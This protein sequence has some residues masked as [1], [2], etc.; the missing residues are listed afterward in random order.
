MIRF[1]RYELDSTQGLTRGSQEVRLTP[2]SLALLHVLAGRPGQVVTKEEL[3]RIVW[4]D[5]AVSDAAL[6]SCIQEL[7]RAL[8][9]DARHPRYIETLHR[10]G[11]RF[12][13]QAVPTEHSRSAA[14]TPAPADTPFVGREAELQRMRAS[15]ARAEGR[16][17][18]VLFV[19]GEPGMGKSALVRAFLAGLPPWADRHVALGQSVEHYGTGEP[20]HPLLEALA[21][22]CRQPQGNRYLVTLRRC[23]PTWLAQLPSLHS[24]GE[25]AAL[26]RRSVG[27]TRD[28]MLRELTDALEA[29]GDATCVVLWLED[30]HWS[31]VSTIDWIAAFARRPEPTR[32]LLIGT[33]RT[34]EVQAGRHSLGAVVD[35]L[36]V[37]GLC[38]EVALSGLGPAEVHTFLALRHPPADSSR[39]AWQRMSSLL[40]TRS[41]G[42]PLFVVN[43]LADLAARGA[44]G[45]TGGKWSVRTD[46]DDAALQIPESIR[47]TIERQLD[48]LE[49]SE[50]ELLDVASVIGLEFS[51]AA[52]A[53]VGGGSAGD[54]E[55]RLVSIARSTPFVRQTGLPTSPGEAPTAGFAFPHSLYR[56]VIHNRLSAG[57]R[58]EL[59]LSAGVRKESAYGDRAWE[60]ASELAVHFEQARDFHRAV[61]YH[62]HAGETARHRSAYK[63]AQ[64]HFRRGLELLR[65][66]PASSERDD[67]EVELRVALGT[68]LMATLGWGAEEVQETFAGAHELCRGRLDA[69]QLFPA[70]WGMWLFHWGRG[71]LDVARDLAEDLLRLAAPSGERALELQARHASW[72]T[73]F[74]RGELDAVQVHTAEGISVYEA[75]RHFSLAARYGDHDAGVCGRMFRARAFALAGQTRK[76]VQ[77]SDEAI[78]LAR[79]LGHPFSLAL[80]LVFA[81]AVHQVRRDAPAARMRAAEAGSIAREQNFSLMRAWAGTLEGWAM[82]EQGAAGLTLIQD[83]IAAARATGSDQFQPHLLALLADA[84]RQRRDADAGLGAVVQALG[85][86]HRTGER[87]YEAELYRLRGEL[88]LLAG[89]DGAARS[90]AEQAFRRAVD[91]AR[92]QG[93]QLLALRAAVSLARLTPN[94]DVLTLLAEQRAALENDLE[95][96][97]AEEA[98]EVLAAQ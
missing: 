43:V 55:A 37:H 40:H 56:E 58:A 41:A 9:D 31:D 77:L 62:R 33:Y 67:R 1:G 87:F 57:R 92:G 78:E 72:A 88:R 54:V 49:R 79:E 38:E 20:Y 21:R 53:D 70:I 26:H 51:S 13:G 44:I 36:R 3:F 65:T 97:D 23:A 19:S 68:A 83:S 2:K 32:V 93:A 71:C 96:P 11:Y 63:E 90:E 84:H 66:L 59:H 7:R 27:V 89:D 48:R 17:R 95:L 18:Q 35:A 81:A 28:R 39:A 86:A 4:P 24:P 34:T 6:T 50:R 22:L 52:V 30:L 29:I 46:L 42:I 25:F 15:L 64:A 12:L 60:V 80:A 10:R 8:Q 45:E 69:P 76:A 14:R 5:T 74:S 94:A 91:I 73:C 85:I 75:D 16:S 61:G 82:V 47:R 98:A